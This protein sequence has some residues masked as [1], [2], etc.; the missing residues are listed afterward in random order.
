MANY[1][2]GVEIAATQ[3]GTENISKVSQEIDHIGTSSKLA[4]EQVIA[5]NVAQTE[6][7]AAESAS[8]DTLKN[9]AQKA[10]SALIAFES[11]KAFSDK[12]KEVIELADEY[13]LLQGRIAAITGSQAEAAVAMASMEDIATRTHT[14]LEA[15]GHTYTALELAMKDSG[16]TQQEFAKFTEAL[17]DSFVVSGV[18]SANAARGVQDLAHALELGHLSGVH[19][20]QIAQ[21]AP[22]ILQVMSK[23]L[24]VTAGDLR[25]LGHQGKLSA[26]VMFDSLVF[27]DDKL[28]ASVASMPL[29]LDK[30]VQD[31]KNKFQE[32]AATNETVSEWSKFVN[33]VLETVAG[34]MSAIGDAGLKLGELGLDLIA[35]NIVKGL[36]ALAASAREAGIAQREA[37]AMAAEAANTQVLAMGKQAQATIAATQAER[38]QI[39]LQVQ[40]ARV[41]ELQ[42]RASLNK[43]DRE[44][45]AAQAA[46]HG[47]K[48]TQAQIEA[49]Q[50]LTMAVERR[51]LAYD[52]MEK[53]SSS[54]AAIEAKQ[55]TETERLVL[56]EKEAATALAQSAAVMRGEITATE[57]LDAA[58]RRATEAKLAQTAAEREA[59]LAQAAGT[60]AIATEAV[61]TEEA[62]VGMLGRVGAAVTGFGA[63]VKALGT[64]LLGIGPLI[65]GIVSWEFGKWLSD[66]SIMA[67][68]AGAAIATY[69]LELGN[70][71]TGIK[72]LVIGQRSLKQ[73]MEDA[74]KIWQD[75]HDLADGYAS[76]VDR[77]AKS[78][79]PLTAEQKKHADQLAETTRQYELAKIALTKLSTEDA[80]HIKVVEATTK[81]KLADLTV[82]DQVNKL[83][84]DEIAKRADA[85]QV[86]I[87]Q[88]IALKKLADEKTSAATAEQS[89]LDKALALQKQLIDSGHTFSEVEKKT[90]QDEKDKTEVLQA[91]AQQARAASEA[92]RIH[93]E[94]LRLE[95]DKAK[96]TSGK[97]EEYRKAMDE[98][99]KQV[100]TLTQAQAEGNSAQERSRQIGEQIAQATKNRADEME[101]LNKIIQD[102]ASNTDEDTNAAEE[103]AQVRSD[104]GMEIAGYTKIIE[105]LTAKQNADNQISAQGA[106][107]ARQLAAAKEQ[108]S[109]STQHE[110]DSLTDRIALDKGY[111]ANLKS[112]S[113]LQA[114]AADISIGYAQSLESQSKAEGDAV[115]AAQAR[116]AVEGL[117]LEKIQQT[118]HAQQDQ[119]VIDQRVAQ[120]QIQLIQLSG[121]SVEQKQ[122]EIQA[123]LLTVAAKEQEIQ[124]TDQLAKAQA[125]QA[126]QAQKSYFAQA[127]AATQAMEANTESSRRAA[128]MVQQS[129]E[130][131]ASFTQSFQGS[132]VS[133][134]AILRE[135][136]QQAGLS[137]Q[138]FDQQLQRLANWD[139]TNGWAT[140]HT[141]EAQL[142][143]VTQA[144]DRSSKAISQFSQSVTE[145]TATTADLARWTGLAAEAQHRLEQAAD[146]AGRTI[147]TLA[148]PVASSLMSVTDFSTIAAKD[149]GA[150]KSAIDA[151][152]NALQQLEDQGKS[153]LQSA[154]DE[155]DRLQGKQG[156]IE[157]RAY[158]AKLAELNALLAKAQKAA[159][160]QAVS[161]IEQAL[162]ATTQAH[163]IKMSQ[164]QAEADA[165]A[166]AAQQ[167]QTQQ[168]PIN[169]IYT[170]RKFVFFFF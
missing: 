2:I 22:E 156:D 38:D 149:M 30:A 107:A 85:A 64:Q 73:I 167:Q 140:L 34:H 42:A 124:A 155:L 27:A 74:N 150:L 52:Q 138:F 118:L 14:S 70:V 163:Q 89:A 161:D 62:A 59:I 117:K 99:A 170:M 84:P 121:K 40:K 69:G 154:Q 9:S 137:L 1:K 60:V 110:I 157:Q 20:N 126:Y 72:D 135:K 12:V 91:A 83:I 131:A 115:G 51:V 94:A 79:P 17:T 21:Q 50:A 139:G 26:E 146:E 122:E 128:A 29:T 112:A 92:A 31:V 43:A 44:E 93:A 123:I 144:Q 164:I 105:D 7:I 28:K 145:G 19:F 77:A 142:N 47:A 71:L 65:S 165:K 160:T 166:K 39:A 56:A 10:L 152:R 116:V 109:I 35:L 127:D 141:L 75:G 67:R 151:A 13:K 159:D 3:T 102:S 132:L 81:A 53:A 8:L 66:N 97:V 158:Q 134:G 76:E 108:Q 78:L 15:L 80:A 169:L 130:E 88:A 103:N 54:L 24:G 148:G 5:S 86:A 90:I 45:L 63:S 129:A 106:E 98:A 119:L 168:Q 16:H 23:Y 120:D 147:T 111:I 33:S 58:T 41:D 32:F 125:Q 36:L 100:K 11:V 61:A 153:A 49:N 133:I 101:S 18:T 136:W 46:V 114:K 96:D 68:Q 37:A 162:Q 6:S 95:A 25:E 55:A 48:G 82:Q 143:A 104:L 4:S 57:A 87:D 113:D